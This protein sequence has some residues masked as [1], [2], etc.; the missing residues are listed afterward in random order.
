MQ[1]EVILAGLARLRA[2]LHHGFF[3]GLLRFAF[4]VVLLDVL[5]THSLWSTDRVA[6]LE[7]AV[8]AVD[9]SHSKKGISANDV[10]LDPRA[11]SRCIKLLL[12]HKPQ[13]RVDEA[14]AFRLQ[15]RFL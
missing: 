13:E 4:P 14:D 11:V 7:V 5:V 3:A 1:H 12:V 15:R 8:R 9:R 10:L 6:R 2:E